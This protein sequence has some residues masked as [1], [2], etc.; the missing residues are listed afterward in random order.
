M[1]KKIKPVNI[2]EKEKAE[3]SALDKFDPNFHYYLY[4]GKDVIRKKGLVVRWEKKVK[5]GKV[6]VDT[7][8]TDFNMNNKAQTFWND[9]ID[10]MQSELTD[11]QKK[12]IKTNPKP[13]FTHTDGKWTPTYACMQ[14]IPKEKIDYVLD[15]IIYRLFEI[16]EG[17]LEEAKF[18]F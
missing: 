13:S 3:Q 4:E 6:E 17:Y 16:S 1:K 15:K 12:I 10:E 11:E 8:S 18:D 9:L 14:N 2:R 7:N 5:Y